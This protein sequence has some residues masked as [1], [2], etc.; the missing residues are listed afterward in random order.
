MP[1]DHNDPDSYSKE[2]RF[3]DK[4]ILLIAENSA[5]LAEEYE[6]ASIVL[7]IRNGVIEI[8]LKTVQFV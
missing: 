7:R 8:D 1:F 3:N 4:N 5:V 6:R 2:V